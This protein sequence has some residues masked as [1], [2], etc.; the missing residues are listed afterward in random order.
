MGDAMGL[1]AGLAVA[2]GAALWIRAVLRAQ[3]AGKLAARQDAA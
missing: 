1:T 3:K 2:I